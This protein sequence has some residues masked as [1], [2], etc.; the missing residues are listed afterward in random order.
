MTLWVDGELTV[1]A[2]QGAWNKV[3]T[4]TIPES[5]RA[6]GVKCRNK[7]GPYGIMGSIQ[8]EDGSS[9]VVTDDS[10]RCRNRAQ[11][12]WERADFVEGDGWNP[13]SDHTHGHYSTANGLFPVCLC[14]C[15]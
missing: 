2:G 9:V 13:A 10:W 3:S 5:T 15:S 14:D 11:P 1:L 8:D 7:S 6:I 4:L 12:G